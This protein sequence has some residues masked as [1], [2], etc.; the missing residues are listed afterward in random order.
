MASYAFYYRLNFWINYFVYLSYFLIK[1]IVAPILW[2]ILKRADRKKSEHSCLGKFAQITQLMQSVTLLIFGNQLPIKKYDKDRD[3]NN[4][5]TMTI[6]KRTLSYGGMMVL[7]VL[8]TTFKIV[9]VGSA[10]NLTILSVTH[11]CSENPTVDCFPQLL[12]GVNDS[13][14]NM[15][16][17]LIEPVQ[18]CNYW[19]SEGVTHKVTFVCFQLGLDIKHFLSTFG[20]LIAFFV[21]AMKTAVAVML[22]LSV[23]CQGGGKD[24]KNVKRKRGCR[25]CLCVDRI[26]VAIIV[27]IIE[28]VLALVS[29][30]WGVSG[31]E[32]DIT[33]N[34]PEFIFV[35][36]RASEVLI[37]FGVIATLLWLPWEEY[38]KAYK[39]KM[40]A[41]KD[42]EEYEISE[43][44][45]EK[46]NV[47]KVDKVYET[48]TTV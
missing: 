16:I 30:V 47:E 15:T 29:F 22:F 3:P 10:L 39:E 34:T 25:T 2:F 40:D 37:V 9:A 43:V 17:S 26:V 1:Y 38:T 8:A 35:A 45:K 14:L 44:Y 46:G 36:S 19:N 31:A 48:I 5:P 27:S 21:Y 11:I 23:W 18:D 4:I 33:H 6:S 28:I 20:G 7:F 13:D 42:G 41:K 24:S 12:P 32:V